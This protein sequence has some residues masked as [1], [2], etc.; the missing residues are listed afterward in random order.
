MLADELELRVGQ[1]AVGKQDPVRKRELA[2]V[3]QQPRCVHRAL[4]FLRASG[5]PRD[6]VRIAR[7][8]SRVARGAVVAQRQRAHHRQE[9]AD[10]QRGELN[11]ALLELV[12]ALLRVEQLR[13]QH[14][15][16]PQQREREQQGRRAS[17]DSRA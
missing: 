11:R 1:T 7:D 10:L 4:V 6:R 17:V 3:V 2:D 8:G 9:H 12:A 16:R 5:G 13:Q 15:E 14:V